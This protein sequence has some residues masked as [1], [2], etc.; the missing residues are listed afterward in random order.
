M[1]YCITVAEP[2][3]LNSSHLKEMSYDPET[4]ELEI[5]FLSGRAYIYRGVPEQIA[6]GLA[7]ARSAGSFFH[8][9]IKNAFD[10]ESEPL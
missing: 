10:S 3:Q 8:Y 6:H 1:R 4:Q 5:R 9:Q 2:I 7:N